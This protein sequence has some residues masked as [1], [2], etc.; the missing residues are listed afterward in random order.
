MVWK[1]Q[2]PQILQVFSLAGYTRFA[3]SERKSE[4][5]GIAQ[6]GV[7]PLSEDFATI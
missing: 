1:L 2:S 6:L 3:R 4:N 7:D 5:S